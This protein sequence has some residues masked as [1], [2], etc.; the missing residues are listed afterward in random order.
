ME[1]ALVGRG[2]SDLLR[3]RPLDCKAIGRQQCDPFVTRL[4]AV[5]TCGALVGLLF[6]SGQSPILAFG[7]GLTKAQLTAI[8]GDVNLATAAGT[9]SAEV[10]VGLDAGSS[11]NTGANSHADVSFNGRALARLS[12]K[13]IL[14]LKNKNVLELSRGAVLLQFPDGAKGKVQA[15]T[16]AA[17]V[18]RVTAVIEYEPPA[19]KFLVLAGT[20]RLYRPAKLGDSILVHPGQMVFGNA[21]APLTDP[22]DFAID[23]FVKTCPLIQDFPALE[24]ER[25]IAAASKRQQREQS[26]KKL[27]ETNLVIFGGGSR[28]SVVDPANVNGAATTDSPRASASNGI[29]TPPAQEVR[30]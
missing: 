1:S 11:I 30:P 7:S 15:G 10:G 8:V 29:P 26:K 13:T 25:A 3:E 19:F 18:S 9:R 23:R 16:I 12:A 5:K 21:S 4:S 24:S 27:L 14:S 28:L 6:A 17:E 22:V 20:G 2:F